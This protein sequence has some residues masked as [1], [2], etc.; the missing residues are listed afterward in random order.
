M[1]LVVCP[2]PSIDTYWMMDDI[3]FGAVNRIKNQHKFPGGKGV[4]VAINIAELGE[5]PTLLGIW[6]GSNGRW[7]KAACEQLQVPCDGVDIERENRNCIAVLS[8]N[9]SVLHTEF[10]EQG[11]EINTDIYQQLFSVYVAHLPS[12]SQII[13]SGSWPPGIGINPYGIFIDAA[14]KNNIPVWIDC[15][16][17]VLQE[18]LLHKPFGVHINQQ[19]AIEICKDMQD[20]IKYFLQHT[21]MLALTEGKKGLHLYEGDKTAH[22]VYPVQEVISTVGC[23]DALLAGIVTA[24]ARNLS[25]STIAKYGAACGAANCLRFEL[26]MFYKEDVE[27]FLQ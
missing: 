2:N 26:G 5:S 18:A 22:A 6:G 19:E 12:V 21:K 20:P 11:P 4:H 14:N 25:L 27:R 15:A 16:G 1:I 7:I 3:K 9:K 23:G 10:L 17:L 24:S 13:L 8:N